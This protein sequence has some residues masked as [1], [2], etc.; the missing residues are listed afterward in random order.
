MYLLFDLEIPAL[1]IYPLDVP[2]RIQKDIC[3]KV[4]SHHSIVNS[5]R[6]ET[7]Q[8]NDFG[9]ILHIHKMECHVPIQKIKAVGSVPI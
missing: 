7:T 2:A 6:S 9:E 3:A 8:G 4:I 1:K 5:T